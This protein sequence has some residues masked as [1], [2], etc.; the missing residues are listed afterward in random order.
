MLHFF[1]CGFARCKNSY[2]VYELSNLEIA[3]WAEYYLGAKT[4]FHQSTWMSG[5]VTENPHDILLGHP[6]WDGR[7]PDVRELTGDL[8]RNWVKDNALSPDQSCHPNTYILMPWVPEFPPSWTQKMPFWEQQLLAAKKI[9]ALC[10]EIW[11]DR[12]ESLPQNTLQYQVK[13]KLV[14]CNMG[15]ASQNFPI[16]KQNFNAIGERQI[17]HVSNLDAYKGFDITCESIEGL[18][19]LLHVGTASLQGEPGLT[20]III[21][22]NQDGSHKKYTVNYLGSIKNDDPEFNYWV[23]EN[24]DFYIHTGR[25]DAQA[26]TILE[27]AV[28]GLVPLVTPESGFAS[29]HAIYLTQNPD[30]NREIIRWALTLP[31]SELLERSRLIR[32]QIQRENNWESIYTTIWDSIITDI[33]A[34][35]H[36]ATSCL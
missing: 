30:Q 19:T 29:P 32:E 35:S 22:N 20:E 9:F 16:I 17:L 27:N 11:M 15:I 21:Q 1:W 34:R 31:E 33:E 6:T 36:I 14:H 24:C 5:K 25:M 4:A 8:E 26:T 28:R 13:D 10:G 23:V 7:T 3:K 2:Q 18:D 12:T